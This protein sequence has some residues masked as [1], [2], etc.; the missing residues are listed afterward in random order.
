MQITLHNTT[1]RFY[2]KFKYGILKRITVTPKRN[3][4]TELTVS[5]LPYRKK[6]NM[7][8]PILEDVVEIRSTDGTRNEEV[9]ISDPM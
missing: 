6:Y 7:A 2:T 8:N 5:K 4:E 3:C 9:S 1:I